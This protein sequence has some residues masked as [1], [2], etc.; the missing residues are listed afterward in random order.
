VP[1]RT[2]N[3]LAIEFFQNALLAFEQAKQSSG[4]QTSR[5]YRFGS[6][7]VE[8]IFAGQSLVPIISPAF[9]H[10]SETGKTP[11]ELLVLLWD[12]ESTGVN[13]PPVPWDVQKYLNDG[14]IWRYTD[15]R[16]R[17]TFNPQTKTYNLIDLEQ[18][19]AIFQTATTV[20]IPQYQSGSPLLQ[21]LEW[22]LDKFEEYILHAGAVGY[23]DR[24]VLLVG[25]GGSGKSTTSLACLDSDLKYVSDDYCLLTN[26]AAPYVSSLYN[27]AKVKLSESGRFFYLKNA[28][29]SPNTNDSEKTLF[30]IFN[31]EFQKTIA[32]FPVCAILIPRITGLP[33]TELQA[34]TS[35][36]ALLALAPSTVF[37]FPGTENHAIKSMGQ[38]VKKVP[39]YFLNLGTDFSEI[40]DCICQVLRKTG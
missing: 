31:Q 19:I 23:A 29:V 7:H 6:H 12:R 38:L 14:E 11:E 4:N 17:I 34:A 39:C 24:G 21:I 13:M 5:R 25:K 20:G 1:S 28:S 16:F 15:Q 35:A 22:W 10:I 26:S 40:A 36:Q 37:H 3:I 32:G 8:L 18:K 27:S 2:S 9:E 33:K 30:F